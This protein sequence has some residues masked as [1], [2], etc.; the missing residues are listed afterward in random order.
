M[1]VK[2]GETARIFF[3]CG[4]PNL[5]SNFHPV[6]NVWTKAWREGSIVN[7]PER[8]VQTVAV[9]PGSCLIVEAEFPVPGEVSLVDHALSRVVSKGMLGIIE[10]EGEAQPDIFNPDLPGESTN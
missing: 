2:V 5:T 3:V 9:P 1:K 8:Y 4:G 10:I 6:G 7:N